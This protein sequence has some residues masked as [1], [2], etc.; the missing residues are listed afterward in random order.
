MIRAQGRTIADL[1]DS[2]DK[3]GHART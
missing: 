1:R 2:L 3:L